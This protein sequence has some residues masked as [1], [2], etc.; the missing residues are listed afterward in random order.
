MKM[1]DAKTQLLCVST[2]INYQVR[3]SIDMA[4][5]TLVSGDT[6]KVVGFTFG[7]RPG[8]GEHVVALRKKYGARAYIIRHLKKINTPADLLVRVYTAFIRP[9]FDYAAPAY[10]TILTDDQAEKLEKMQRSSLKTIFG[11]ETPYQECLELAGLQTLRERRQT[12]FENFARKAYGDP[13][14]GGR[15]FEEKQRCNYGLRHENK[16]VQHFANRDRLLNAPIYRYRR[17]INDEDKKNKLQKR[18]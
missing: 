12:L 9:I 1:N 2:A 14:F 8:A 5:G 16:V 4:G 15:W 3:A 6:L 18:T 11:L 7:R 13:F 10:H 17:H